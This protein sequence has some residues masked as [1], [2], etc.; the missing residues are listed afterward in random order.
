MWA[1]LHEEDS[2]ALGCPSYV[3]LDNLKEGSSLRRDAQVNPYEKASTL[4]TSNRSLDDWAKLLGDAVVAGPLPD[5]IMHH[6]APAQVR[7]QELASEGGQPRVAK[8][9]SA[10]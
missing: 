9:A 5:R 8:R 10:D 4:I 2:H 3:V 1:R 6:G 7:G